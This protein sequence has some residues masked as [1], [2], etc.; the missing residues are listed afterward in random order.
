[1]AF[2]TTP[3]ALSVGTEVHSEIIR[4][5]KAY[6]KQEFGNKYDADPHF[7]FII[8]AMPLNKAKDIELTLNSYFKD[9]KP[10]KLKLGNLH[11]EE[12]QRFYSIPIVGEE[13]MT[14]HSEFIEILNPLRDDY[15]REKDLVR[16]NEGKTDK[17]EEE[18][19]HKY[20]YLRV[21][22][23]FTPHIT[24]GN[25]QTENVDLGSITN[26][27]NNILGNLY[28]STL[29]ITELR[30]DLIEDAQVQTDYK[31]LWNKTYKL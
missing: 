2:K 5:A 3:Y 23:K 6:L 27:L 15:I 20:G 18:Y 19:I 22:S 26:N 29:N 31:R 1:M 28:G 9:K 13:V 25:L 11:Y 17:L 12:K 14:L 8:M 7:N 10:L 21:L 30:A 16:I 24:I 4:S